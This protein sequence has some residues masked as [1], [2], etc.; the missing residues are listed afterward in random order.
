[1]TTSALSPRI[2]A[3]IG[4][5]APFLRFM[6]DSTWSRRDPGDPAA[7]DFVV[8]NPHE[9]PLPE[10]VAALERHVPPR[11]ARWFAYKTNEDEPRRIVADA[12]RTQRGVPF[13]SD[14]VF[15]TNGA[16][17]A[18]SVA[19]ATLVGADDEVVFISPPW[20]FY[21][22]II[23]A[24]GATP[25][26][27]RVDPVTFDLDLD[28]I[29]AALTPRTRAII[30]NSPHNPTGR[31]Y[32]PDVSSA[33]AEIL[34]AASERF[35]RPIY[36]L[37]D[38]AYSRIVFDGRRF[39]SP[40]EAYPWSMVLYTYGKTLLTPGQRI[41]YIALPPALPDRP[42]LREGLFA[43]QLVTGFAFPNAL[44]Q[45]ALADLDRLSID[46]AG[47]QRRR[48]R[49]VEA[50]T[51]MGYEAHV[52]EGTFYV[53]VRTPEADDRAF[54][55]RLAAHRVFVLPGSVVEM[56]G[57]FRLSLTASDAMVDQSLAG[58]AAAFRDARGV[59]AAS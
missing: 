30:V 25:V 33:L 53:M 35:G 46:V 43:A 20:F 55:E 58:F 12:L 57:T 7:C 10:F 13:E 9:M 54:C 38:E 59:A 14:D 24:Y 44:L 11:D 50:L 4:A 49:M 36:L 3:A 40:T 48:D 45:H 21:A 41:G 15:L 37:S 26:R 31:I 47:L 27:V 28:A 5:M 51:G 8:G 6:Q 17:A 18:L 32:G 1:M 34:T 29:A 42:V 19:L 23:A 56:P 52:P 22:S 2:T 39:V 16:F